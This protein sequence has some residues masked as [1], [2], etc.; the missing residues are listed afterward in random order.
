MTQLSRLIWTE[1]SR[2]ES[3]K[4]VPEVYRFLYPQKCLSTYETA[5]LKS[6]CQEADNWSQL[7]AANNVRWEVFYNSP[8]SA[9]QK[10]SWGWKGIQ[11]QASLD[12][13][14][15]NR[16]ATLKSKDIFLFRCRI[17]RGLSRIQRTDC[18]TWKSW[19]ARSL[20]IY[21]HFRNVI[22]GV[23]KWPFARVYVTEMR[24]NYVIIPRPCKINGTSVK[25][26]LKE[27]KI[28]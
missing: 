6:A 9:I 19:L 11:E 2:F 14:T 16:K 17:K 15:A 20:L 18:C 8:K 27:D 3:R 12:A 26:P 21:Q 5:L 7:H 25:T 28:W 4:K 22:S 10:P 24:L 1:T 23:T 13:R